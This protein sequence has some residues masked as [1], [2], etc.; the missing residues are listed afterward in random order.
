MINIGDIVSENLQFD[1]LIFLASFHHLESLE[2]RIKVLQDA[3]KLLA[4]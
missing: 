1:A 2:E 3:R 4:P